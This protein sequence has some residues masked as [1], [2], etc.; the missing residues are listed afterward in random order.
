[1]VMDG[2]WLVVVNIQYSV[3][4]LCGRIMHLKLLS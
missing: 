4:M 2:A 1:M 3:Q